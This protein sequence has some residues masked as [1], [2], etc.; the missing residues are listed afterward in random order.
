MPLDGTGVFAPNSKSDTPSIGVLP[1]INFQVFPSLSSILERHLQVDLKRLQQAEPTVYS[2]TAAEPLLPVDPVGCIICE[3]RPAEVIET[4]TKL[5]VRLSQD[6]VEQLAKKI[7][8]LTIELARLREEDEEDVEEGEPDEK[9]KEKPKTNRKKR[10][11]TPSTSAPARRAKKAK[12]DE[13]DLSLTEPM[14][15][16]SLKKE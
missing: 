10:A 12:R 13:V 5:T 9:E 6:T 8:A 7:A 16:R 15:K 1:P 11:V 14:A 2:A 4:R 3:V